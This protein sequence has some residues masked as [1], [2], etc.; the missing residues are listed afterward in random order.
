MSTERIR[1]ADLVAERTLK[2]GSTKALSKSLAAYLLDNNEVDQLDSILRDVSQDWAEAGLVEVVAASAHPLTDAV[3]TDI[4]AQVKKL[5]PGAK[6]IIVSRTIDPSIVG[7]VK[8]SLPGQQLDMSVEAK[9]NKFKQLT[10]NG[11]A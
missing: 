6:Q 4:K 11:K 3:V 1:I 7:G 5:Y 2:D 9:L 10:V 8:L